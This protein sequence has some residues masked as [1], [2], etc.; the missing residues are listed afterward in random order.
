MGVIGVLTIGTIFG[1]AIAHNPRSE[2]SE[3][4]ALQEQ[5][6]KLI[7]L[8]NDYD[9]IN[10]QFFIMMQDMEIVTDLDKIQQDPERFTEIVNMFDEKKNRILFDQGIIYEKRS[11]AGLGDTEH[12]D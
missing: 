6:E 12:T 9:K 4:E 8:V 7:K 3:N 1:Y 2:M 5:N 11:Q 10:K